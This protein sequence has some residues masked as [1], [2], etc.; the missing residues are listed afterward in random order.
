MARSQIILNR[1]IAKQ[2]FGTLSGTCFNP[3]G[4]VST[5]MN[6]FKEKNFEVGYWTNN[7]PVNSDD[8]WDEDLMPQDHSWTEAPFGYLGQKFRD[9]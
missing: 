3:V 6:R 5:K 1:K 9:P 4:H 2:S 8:F 7:L